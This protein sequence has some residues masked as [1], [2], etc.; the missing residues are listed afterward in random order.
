MNEISV[1]IKETPGLPRPLHCGKTGKT[2]GE[3]PSADTA[4][5]LSLDCPDPRIVRSQLPLC[6]STQG[7]GFKTMTMCLPNRRTVSTPQPEAL[8]EQRVG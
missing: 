7:V 3:E 1:L 6:L 4:G 5:P 8:Q 2:A